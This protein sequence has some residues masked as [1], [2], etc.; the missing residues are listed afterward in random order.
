MLHAS[1]RT[2]GLRATFQ[3]ILLWVFPIQYM[4]LASSHVL[5]HVHQTLRLLDLISAHNP[6][7]NLACGLQVDPDPIS[8][9]VVSNSVRVHFGPQLVVFNTTQAHYGPVTTC[10][11]LWQPSLSHL[12]TIIAIYGYHHCHL[13]PLSSWSPI[14]LS[15]VSGCPSAIYHSSPIVTPQKKRKFRVL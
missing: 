12:T 10:R 6:I 7:H 4:H 8:K 2:Y 5:M 3:R 1:T 15:T 11:H 13:R 14:T 9:L